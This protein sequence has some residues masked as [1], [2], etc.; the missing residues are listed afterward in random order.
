M[1]CSAFRKQRSPYWKQAHCAHHLSHVIKGKTRIAKRPNSYSLEKLW[2][3]VVCLWH[4]LRIETEKQ[5]FCKWAAVLWPA[6][7]RERA[8]FS[9]WASIWRSFGTDS[10]LVSFFSGYSPQTLRPSFCCE[11]WLSLQ[12]SKIWNKLSVLL[13][14]G[15][16]FQMFSVHF[17]AHEIHLP[18]PLE[19]LGLFHIMFILYFFLKEKLWIGEVK[20]LFLKW[21]ME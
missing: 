9:S 14:K 17:W 11:V 4:L 16:F 5:T 1:L 13:A 18:V 8:G 21:K 19:T 7:V 3:R 20:S 12:T 2:R 10:G 15:L 6:L